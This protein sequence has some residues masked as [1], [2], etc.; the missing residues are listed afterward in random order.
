MTEAKRDQ[1]PSLKILTRDALRGE[2]VAFLTDCAARRLS[3]HTIRIYRTQLDAFCAW[4]PKSAG[5]LTPADVRAYFARLQEGH[6]A[7]GVHQAYRV[8]K[9]FFRWLAAE[10]VLSASPMERIRSPKL[11]AEPLDPVPLDD[12]RAMLTTCERKT[13]AGDRDRAI[14]LALLDSGCR[15]SEF[16]ALNLVDL[17][18]TTGALIVRHGKGDKRR[19]VFLSA[20]TRREVVRYLRYRPDAG[21]NAPLFA[22]MAGGRLTYSGLRQIIR[23][24]AEMAGVKAPGLHS[25]RRAFALM[26][27]RAGI[28]LVSLQRLMGHADLSILRRYL[29]QTEDDLRAAHERSAPV[30]RL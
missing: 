25:F 14:L 21:P 15:A 28:D 10:G 17:D 5:E 20:K 24:R 4:T 23:R 27:L 6:N 22:T 19:V 18:M 13:H 29:Q 16:V 11:S 9:T 30:D 7:G 12:L 1:A 26:S 2:V 3:H 8:L